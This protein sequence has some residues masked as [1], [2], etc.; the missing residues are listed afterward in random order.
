[1]HV[2]GCWCTSLAMLGLRK[3]LLECSWLC[4]PPSRPLRDDDD[5]HDDLPL[6]SHP[7]TPTTHPTHRPLAQHQ[8]RPTYY[9][10]CVCSAAAWWADALRRHSSCIAV[11]WQAPS[12]PWLPRWREV[13]PAPP[14][15]QTRSSL[16]VC[17]SLP[18]YYVYASFTGEGKCR[19]LLYPVPLIPLSLPP[20]LP[21]LSLHERQHPP[22]GVPVDSRDGSVVCQHGV[23]PQCRQVGSGAHFP[24]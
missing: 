14:L 15:P 19:L 11:A 5:A 13:R 17:M 7:P 10:Q 16:Q 6:L 4:G 18:L 22:G 24:R 23:D 1:M 9:E 21:R 3:R 8:S 2:G 20:S 12:K